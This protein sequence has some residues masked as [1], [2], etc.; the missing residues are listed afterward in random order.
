M[1]LFQSKKEPSK[2]EEVQLSDINYEKLYVEPNET[3]MPDYGWVQMND[4]DKFN[5]YTEEY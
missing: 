2:A 5:N 3:S 1:K 4:A